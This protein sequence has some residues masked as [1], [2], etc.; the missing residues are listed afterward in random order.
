MTLG[1][2]L[3]VVFEPWLGFVLVLTIGALIGVGMGML[4]L[5]SMVATQ[6]DAP[7]ERLGVATSA[8]MLARLFGGAF[9]IARVGSV[10]FSRKERDPSE[11]SDP[12]INAA[13]G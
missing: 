12:S 9:G 6:N 7:R 2:G 11:L 13:F 1:Y 8:V 4:T 5:T 10:L 3:F